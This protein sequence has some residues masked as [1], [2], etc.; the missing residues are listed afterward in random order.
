FPLDPSHDTAGPLT[1]TVTHWAIMLHVWAGPDPEHP[2]TGGARVP[3]FMRGLSEGLTGISIDVPVNYVWPGYEPAV[4]AIV[5]AAIDD[6]KSLGATIVDV[7]LPWAEV[8]RGVYN[9]VVATESAEYHR[10]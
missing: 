4:E 3:D 1:R 5:R 7:E 2:A 10:R 8:S 9:A 6:L